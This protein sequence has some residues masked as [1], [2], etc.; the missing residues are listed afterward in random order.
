MSRPCLSG[1]LI[2]NSLSRGSLLRIAF[3][4]A[5]AELSSPD[6]VDLLRKTVTSASLVAASAQLPD[7]D[8]LAALQACLAQLEGDGE[9][10]SLHSHHPL[11]IAVIM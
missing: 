9:P 4:K 5:D 10:A 6:L 2:T 8:G 3:P 11:V 1:G 7:V